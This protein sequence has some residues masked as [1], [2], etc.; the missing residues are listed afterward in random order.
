MIM[1]KKGLLGR[2]TL[3][4]FKYIQ[5]VIMIFGTRVENNKHCFY[6]EATT[7]ATFIK[8]NA[9]DIFKKKSLKR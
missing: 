3:L 4:F 5:T 6:I 2:H 9:E 7:M 1:F 8:N